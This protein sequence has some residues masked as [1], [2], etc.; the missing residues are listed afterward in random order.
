[1]SSVQNS[2]NWWAS[3]RNAAVAR[4]ADPARDAGRVGHGWRRRTS[5]RRWRAWTGN[6]RRATGLAI[7]RVRPD[8]ALTTHRDHRSSPA[9]TRRRE[10]PAEWLRT[11]QRACHVSVKL[12]SS[13][14][15][16]TVR[17]IVKGADGTSPIDHAAQPAAHCAKPR[18]RSRWGSAR[19]LGAVGSQPG[20]LAN[21]CGSGGSA[22]ALRLS[23]LVAT[24]VA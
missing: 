18:S 2:T 11:A 13:D 8:P 5:R 23:V 6:R 22:E 24:M 9:P 20:E 17:W 7:R 14:R 1:M 21:I 15:M 12:T 4:R 10:S 3:W 16:N 19:R